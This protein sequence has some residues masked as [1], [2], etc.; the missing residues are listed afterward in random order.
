MKGVI[1]QARMGSTRLP[2]K[3]IKKINGNI[4]ILDLLLKRLK[5]SKK[6]DKIIIA[7]TK[8]S[9]DTIIANIAKDHGVEI[10]RG[11]EN[12]VLKR[13]YMAAKKFKINTIIRI[14]SDCPFIDPY[15]LDKMLIIFEEYMYD[16]MRNNYHS[17][18]PRGMDIE[19]LTWDTLKYTYLNATNKASKEHVTYFIY[20]NPELFK[21]YNYDLEN[22]DFIEGLRITVDDDDDLIMMRELFKKIRE[23]KKEDDFSIFDIIDIVKLNPKLLN[24][25]KHVKQKM[26]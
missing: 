22:L 8:N 2:G 10:F 18:L 1:I 25:N 17:N 13:Y 12:N 19:I 16:Y 20:N 7:T 5:L 14:T 15:L 26:P 6:I 24:I 9:S 21:I 23:L 11:S 3:V 4:T